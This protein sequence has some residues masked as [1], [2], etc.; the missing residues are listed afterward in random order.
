MIIQLIPVIRKFK[1]IAV[2]G[3]YAGCMNVMISQNNCT[4][5]CPN[6]GKASMCIA[7]MEIIIIRHAIS[8][9]IPKADD[10]LTAELLNSSQCCLKALEIL[11]NV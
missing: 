6:Q 8:G 2:F 4:A 11:M 1:K 9:Y 10:F 5:I 7:C 3:N